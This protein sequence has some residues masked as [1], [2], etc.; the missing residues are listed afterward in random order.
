MTTPAP[1]P[2]PAPQS[3]EPAPDGGDQL[4]DAGKKALQAERARAAAAEKQAK[5]LQ[6]QLDA[7]NAANMSAQ[8]RA[9]KERDDAKAAADQAKAE[10]TRWRVAAKHGISDDD[11][12]T[13]LTGT[14]EATLTRQAQRL[15]ELNK[16]PGTPRPDPSQGARGKPASTGDPAKDFATF[17][18]AQLQR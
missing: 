8:E 5:A 14:D 6:T 16:S 13:F 2:E 7:I 12:E 4:G 17:L 1:T 3:S 11:A 9:E 10:A 15:A 18:G